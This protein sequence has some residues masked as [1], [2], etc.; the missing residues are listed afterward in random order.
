M[1]E[2]IITKMQEN[3]VSAEELKETT[4]E[5]LEFASKF[6]KQSSELKYSLWKKTA[7]V[8]GAVIGGISGATAGVLLGGPGVAAIFGLEAIEVCVGTG[9]GVLLGST[10]ALACSPHF[11]KRNF[12]SFGKQKLSR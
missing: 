2:N 9:V 5:L 1:A 6:K 10:S 3:I 8:S 4:D 12:V 7:I 11:W